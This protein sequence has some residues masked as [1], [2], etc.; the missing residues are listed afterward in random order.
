MLKG[1]KSLNLNGWKLFKTLGALDFKVG[2]TDRRTSAIRNIHKYWGL[3]TIAALCLI[4][5]ILILYFTRS[6][7][8]MSGDSVWYMMGADNML[9]GNGYSRTS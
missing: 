1:M 2:K 4:G 7:L 8:G 6:D 5:V 3:I 9:A